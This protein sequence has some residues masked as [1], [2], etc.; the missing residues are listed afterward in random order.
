MTLQEAGTAAGEMDY[1]AESISV[2]CMEQR[3]R[4]E[5]A[6]CQKLSK[7]EEILTYP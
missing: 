1:A 7:M 5:A 6:L 4:Q 2:K 3:A